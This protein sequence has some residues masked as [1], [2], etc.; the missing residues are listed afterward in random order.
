MKRPAAQTESNRWEDYL[1]PDERLLWQGAPATGL[2]FTGGGL[3]KSAFGVFF[4]AFSVFWVTMASSIGHGTAFPVF[5]VP[6]VLVGLWLVVGHWFYDAYKR[7]HAR[8]ALTTR[9]AIIARSMMGRKLL[10]YE[11]GRNS[12]IALIEGDLDTVNFDRRIYHTK[13]GTQTELIGFRFIADG[14][15]VFRMLQ[16]IKDGKYE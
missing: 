9:R 6:F 1:D 15:K 5:G 11:I 8:Y 2:R 10:S 16:D 4:L 3:A 12:P 13:N 14:R 7:K